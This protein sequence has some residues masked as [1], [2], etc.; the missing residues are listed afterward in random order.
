VFNSLYARLSVALTLVLLLV[1]G[2]FIGTSWYMSKQHLN[3]VVQ[4]FNKNLAKNLITERNLIQSGELNK[5]TLKEVF[6]EYMTIN[7]NIEIYLLDVDGNIISF[8]APG[9]KVIRKKVD[10]AP[11]RSFLQNK[12]YQPV[13]GDDPRSQGPGK[14]FSVAPINTSSGMFGYLYVVLRGEAYDAVEQTLQQQY[15]IKLVQR[16]LLICLLVGLIAGLL[17]LW[18]VTR[19]LSRLTHAVESFHSPS[20]NLSAEIDQSET[21]NGDEIQRLDHAFSVMSQR[22]SDQIQAL[23]QKDQNRRN[24]VAN[25]SH[26]LRTPLS[27]VLGYLET[28]HARSRQISAHQQ[29]GFVDIALRNAHRLS[30]LIDELFELAKLE[31]GGVTPGIEPFSLTDLVQDVVQQQ[32][33]SARRKGVS[34]EAGPFNEFPLVLGD[35]SLI[36]RVLEN[37]IAN[38]IYHVQSGDQIKVKLERENTKVKVAVWDGGQQIDEAEVARLFDRFYQGDHRDERDPGAGLGLS[39]ARQIL[40]LHESVIEV[41]NEETGGKVFSFSLPAV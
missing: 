38:A 31:A 27:A 34:L 30:E 37:L 33:L 25:I 26:D 32:K 12:D 2:L 16:V 9:D 29:E 18:T 21:H 14:A 22:I 6:V 11:I 24:L 41:C 13:L 4:T 1:G 36:Q 23:E 28:L 7:P 39:I 5:T 20:D 40:S 10:L 17:I 8:S 35:I 15:L 19:R 3:L